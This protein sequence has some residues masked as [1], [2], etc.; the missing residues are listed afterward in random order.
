MG[1]SISH[2]QKVANKMQLDPA[3]GVW[4]KEKI[5]RSHRYISC[6]TPSSEDGFK[7]YRLKNASLKKGAYSSVYI[8]AIEVMSGKPCAYKIRRHQAPASFNPLELP[9]AHPQKLRTHSQNSENTLPQISI[10]EDTERLDCGNYADQEIQFE[11]ESEEAR[12]LHLLRCE[13]ER[14]PELK[15]LLPLD[16]SGKPYIPFVELL[17]VVKWADREDLVLE[18]G[19]LTL[20]NYIQHPADYKASADKT[21]TFAKQLL[22]ILKL[23]EEMDVVLPDFKSKNTII[24]LANDALKLIDFDAIIRLPSDDPT[25]CNEIQALHTAHYLTRKNSQMLKEARTNNAARKALQYKQ[26]V[27]FAHT[28][29]ELLRQFPISIVDEKSQELHIKKKQNYTEFDLTKT[30]AFAKMPKDLQNLFHTLLDDKL[31][32]LNEAELDRPLKKEYEKVYNTICRAHP[33]GDVLTDPVV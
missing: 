13:V 9:S 10:L 18:K 3:S 26:R 19:D 20:Q 14:N 15:K 8:D 27:S 12:N 1:C 2:L 23:L 17:D 32:S 33:I 4:P 30:T 16:A 28:L 24:T 31:P 11:G 22:A 6:L 25:P 7:F 5:T 29:F 21:W